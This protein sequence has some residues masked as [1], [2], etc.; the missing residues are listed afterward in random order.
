L[1][2]QVSKKDTNCILLFCPST[3]WCILLGS[4]G[5]GEDQ[6]GCIAFCFAEQSAKR[7]AADGFHRSRHIPSRAFHMESDQAPIH[8]F[9]GFQDITS[10]FPA[11]S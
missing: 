10:G 11:G 3:E 6:R 8:G 1:Q 2:Q 4:S 9:S 7:D 5:R